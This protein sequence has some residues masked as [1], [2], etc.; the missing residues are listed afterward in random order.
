MDA[1]HAATDGDTQMSNT[2]D[3]AQIDPTLEV[4]TLLIEAGFAPADAVEAADRTDSVEDARALLYHWGIRPAPRQPAPV[5]AAPLRAHVRRN[6]GNGAVDA[7]MVVRGQEVLVPASKGE[8]VYTIGW[9]NAG[10]HERPEWIV[11]GC[12]C[13]DAEMRGGDC[14]HERA[15]LD[16][17]ESVRWRNS[18]W[19]VG[20]QAAWGE[21]RPI[22][23]GRV[24]RR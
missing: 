15:A 1:A 14:K 9:R 21:I 12:S 8:T 5:K 2:A 20:E 23:R 13:K 19:W 17:L 24:N 4:A 10:T 6:I 3:H 22:R 11:W 7:Q 18:G 16:A